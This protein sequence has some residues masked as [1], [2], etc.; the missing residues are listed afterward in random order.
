MAAT[1]A[2]QFK[3]S[4]HVPGCPPF[5]MDQEIVEAARTFCEDTWIWQD[6]PASEQQLVPD[7]ALAIFPLTIASGSEFV[8]ISAVTKN[9]LY[10]VD[11]VDFAADHQTDRVI[12]TYPPAAVEVV[13]VKRIYKPAANAASLPDWMLSKHCSAIAY[14]ATS[15]LCLMK[16]KEWSDPKKA[17]LMDSLYMAECQNVI[18]KALK[19]GTG[20]SLT[21]HPRDFGF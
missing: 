4:P 21:V 5:L 12:F 19:G 9:G 20:A 2:F 17:V 13:K 16:D 8:G 15:R 6:A 1:S 10:L 11:G 7:G 3:V 18:A 14:L